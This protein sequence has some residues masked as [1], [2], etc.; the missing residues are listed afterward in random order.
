MKKLENGI[1]APLGFRA[2]AA[3]AG[4]KKPG[5]TRL[6][7]T[8]IVSDKPASVAGVFTTN[9]VFA[10]P[11]R[12]CREVCARGS[13][14]AVFANSGNANACTGE[15]G[16]RDVLATAALAGELL[17]V[18][19]GEVCVAS[20]GV[21]GV[22]MPM[23]RLS[24]GVHACAGALSETGSADA[25]RAIMT[26]DTVPKETAVEVPVAGGAVRIGGIAKGSGMIAPNMATM[27]CFLTTDARIRPDDLR[28]LLREA[29]DQSFNCMCVDN[30]MSTNDTLLCLANGASG[31]AELLPGTP[32]FERFG[33]ALAGLCVEIAKALVRDGEG[34]T[35]FVAIEV[36]GAADVAGARQVA[37]SV[38]HSQ[39]CKTAFYGQDANWGRIACAAGYSGADFDA[40][41]LD[42]HIQGI[43]VLERGQPTRYSEEEIQVRMGEP[44]LSVRLDLHSGS[45]RAVFWTSDLSLDYVKINADYRT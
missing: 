22:P 20:T 35:K 33:A 1:C 42:V 9:R 11:V 39:L 31:T 8:L 32:D 13:A 23:D 21:I 28:G 34:A 15:Q 14:R 4:V 10:A 43:Q 44:E 41:L 30:D 40:A 6:D 19:P 5:T 2:G 18:T 24:K 17:G 25:A 27:L 3:A 36:T 38:A 12:Y 7:C 45:G 26:T 37:R 29:A 16:Y